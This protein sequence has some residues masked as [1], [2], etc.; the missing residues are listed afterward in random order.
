M[1][2]FPLFELDVVDPVPEMADE[3][4]KNAL[5]NAL[6]LSGVT[7]GDFAELS[8]VVVV[9]NGTR[10]DDVGLDF[11]LDLERSES[12][13]K[14]V[15]TVSVA[16]AEGVSDDVERITVFGLKELSPACICMKPWPRSFSSDH[17]SD[18]K[19]DRN[20]LTVDALKSE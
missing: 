12:W 3:L 13:G 15:G 7:T 10:V 1:S 11:E 19:L 14:S 2:L 5:G 20:K 9:S 16:Q 8:A 4:L 18:Q 17:G 6:L